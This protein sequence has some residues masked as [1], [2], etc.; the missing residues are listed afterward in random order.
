MS[1]G[2]QRSW[3]MKKTQGAFT[4]IELLVVIAIIAILA[5]L[6]LPALSRAKQRAISVAC[7]NNEKQLG[8]AWFM[9]AGDN[10]DTLPSNSDKDPIAGIN[11]ANNWICPY[12]ISM[13]WSANYNNNFNPLYLTVNDTSIGVAELGNYVANNLKIFVCPA[14]HYLSSVQRSSGA[15]STNSSRIR[16]VSMDGAMGGG[17][18]YFAGIWSQFYNVKKSS[19][20]HYPGPSGCWLITDEHP[21]SDDDASF[22]VNPAD[23]GGTGGDNMWTELPGSMHGQSAGMVFGDGHSEI[24]KW[25]GGTTTQPVTYKTYLQ[26]ITVGDAPSQGDLHWLAQR[27]PLN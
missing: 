26:G 4:L 13:D 17:S 6:L 16:S 24:H 10:A 14:D 15:G 18:K 1:S 2:F 23:A 19:D 7:M 20:M 3:Q 22:F 27:T 5:S 12:G 11:K 8:L 9:Y 25:Q 21:D